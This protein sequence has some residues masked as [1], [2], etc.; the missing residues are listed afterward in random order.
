MGLR[1]IFGNVMHAMAD[2]LEPK[3]DAFDPRFWADIGNMSAA[4]VPVTERN[5]SQLGAVQAVRFGLSGAMSSL[6]IMVF[7][8]GPN[9]E[10]IEQPEHPVAE[11]L[12]CRPNARNTPAEFIGEIAWHLSYWRNAYCLIHPSS[13]YAIGELEIIHPRRKVSV[14]KRE[15]GRIY[16]TFNRVAGTPNGQNAGGSDTYRDDQIWHLRGNPLEENG[17]C[18]EGI[19][20]SAR[21]VFGRAIAVNKYGNLWFKNSGQTGGFYEHPGNFKDKKDEEDFLETARKQSTGEN[22]HRDRLLKYGI[23]YNP[24]KVTNAEAQLLETENRSDTEIFGLW[25]FPPHRAARMD[26]ATNNNIEQ[27]SLDF[28]IYTLMPLAVAIE[29]AAE[30]DLL[31]DNE[32]NEDD[33]LF[34]EFNFAELLRGDLASTYRA[35]LLGRQGEWL[36]ANDCRRILR[37]NPRTDPDGDT[38]ENPITKDAGAAGQGDTPPDTPTKDEG[39]GS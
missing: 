37:M 4:G 3:R 1:S 9:G 32:D 17:L 5:V 10:R 33:E 34:I 11:L 30:R 35:L 20:D 12:G 16:Y 13:E 19:W 21:E 27:Q 25:S 15:D 36:S 2:V 38:Y 8:R 7:K 18:G 31:L 14:E 24:L 6:P 26:R 28:V 39:A 22:R 23:K 29:Q